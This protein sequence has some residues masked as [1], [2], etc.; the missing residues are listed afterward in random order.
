MYRQDYQRIRRRPF[1]GQKIDNERIT[2]DSMAYF[3]RSR[4]YGGPVQS[5]PQGA[6]HDFGSADGPGFSGQSFYRLGTALAYHGGCSGG[7]LLSPRRQVVL[8]APA[9]AC[10]CRGRALG[11]LD[12]RGPGRRNLRQYSRLDCH[13]GPAAAD[14]ARTPAAIGKFYEASPGEWPRGAGGRFHDDGGQCCRPRHVGLPPGYPLAQTAIYRYRR[15]VLYA[16]QLVQGTFPC[17]VVAHHHLAESA[18]QPLRGTRHPDR[19]LGGHQGSG[20]DPGKGVPVF[21]DDRDGPDGFADIVGV[22]G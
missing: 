9:T 8:P 21:C 12:R 13:P 18:A 14:L 20:P 17:L 16:H 2:N 3:S 10:C 1:R 7:D 11:S 15:L 4:L 19:L 22:E 6:G 5:G